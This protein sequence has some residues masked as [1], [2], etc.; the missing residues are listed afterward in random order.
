MD[1]YQLRL[2]CSQHDHSRLCH[3]LALLDRLGIE[4]DSCCDALTVQYRRD[5]HAVARSYISASDDATTKERMECNSDRLALAVHVT[6]KLA[7][8]QSYRSYKFS[9]VICTLIESAAMYAVSMTVTL[10]FY[11]QGGLDTNFRISITSTVTGLAP[12][13][14]A[15]QVVCG[16]T[17]PATTWQEPPRS[18]LEFNHTLDP[19]ST[20]P[21]MRLDIHEDS[22]ASTSSD[23]RL[24]ERESDPEKE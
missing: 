13:L 8:L 6:D 4:V 3:S 18:I 20:F 12:A 21:T 15:V 5:R 7:Q 10:A 2:I 22:G 19:T 11:K 9:R 23:E 24:T 17:R 16:S 1:A 14:I